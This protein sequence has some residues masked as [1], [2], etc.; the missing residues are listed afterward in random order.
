MPP[1]LALRRVTSSRSSID[2]HQSNL[3]AGLC[4]CAFERGVNMERRVL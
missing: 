2:E 1:S 3:W 4:I